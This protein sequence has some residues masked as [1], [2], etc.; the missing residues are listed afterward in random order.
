MPLLQLA[1]TPEGTSLLVSGECFAPVLIHMAE[2]GVS[3]P[4]AMEVASLALMQVCK[5]LSFMTICFLLD[6]ANS[7]FRDRTLYH[8][9]PE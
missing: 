4:V 9:R 2:K 8:R 5:L 7:L 6:F 1:A 3:T